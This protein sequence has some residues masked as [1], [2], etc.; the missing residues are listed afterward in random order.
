M[1]AVPE[2]GSLDDVDQEKLRAFLM[3]G[4]VLHAQPT[5]SNA[6]GVIVDLGNGQSGGGDRFHGNLVLPPIEDCDIC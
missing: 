5:S 3:P 2:S 1:S 4:V 6:A